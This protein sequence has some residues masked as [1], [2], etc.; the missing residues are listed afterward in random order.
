MNLRNVAIGKRLMAGFS[1]LMAVIVIY[2]VIGFWNTM[3]VDA[4]INQVIGGKAGVASEGPGQSQAVL[5]NILSDNKSV[6]ITILIFGIIAIGGGTVIS[7]YLT[8]SITAP[9]KTGVA[10]AN[11]LAA[12]KLKAEASV[13]GKD[14]V[15]Q[16]LV[17]MVHMT[18]EWRRTVSEVKSTSESVSA[19]GEQLSTSAEQLSRGSMEQAQKATHVATSA[20]EMSQSIM[21]VARNTGG[22]ASSAGNTVKIAQEGEVIVGQAVAEVR[23]I[24]DTVNSSAELV[25]S[26]GERSKQI[27]EIVNVINDI[28]DQT[29][30]LA[31]NAAIEAARAGEQGRG[32]AVVA[33]EVRKLAERTAGATSEIAGM[34]KVIQDEVNRAVDAMENATG[35]VAT[36]VDLSMQGGEAL[37]AILKSVNELQVM[38]Q[39]I[40]SAT[41]EMSAT[42]EQISKDIEQIAS[43]SREATAGSE[44]TSRASGEL[45]RLSKALGHTVARFQLS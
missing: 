17:A 26:L 22:I 25:R 30:L 37:G 38:V 45:S 4:H 21:N 20:E 9:L 5:S 19:A 44:Q 1:L 43:V 28:A 14:E 3:S 7:T 27:G 40:A 32:F 31:L 18:E 13:D 6:R 35:K 39:Q 16:L 24:A 10:L 34:I 29:N 41:D 42:S 2:C 15:A 23:E 11:Q 8:R 33:D 36:G 12:G